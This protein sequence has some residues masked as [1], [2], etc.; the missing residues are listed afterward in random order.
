MST[1]LNCHGTRL[2]DSSEGVAIRE[3]VKTDQTKEKKS[4]NCVI[5][6]ADSEI[7]RSQPMK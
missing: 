5:D 6:I 2:Q 3:D 1:A 7:T 4:E